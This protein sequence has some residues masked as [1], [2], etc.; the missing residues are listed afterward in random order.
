MTGGLL[1]QWP[2]ATRFGRI[3]PKTKF[4]EHATIAPSVRA[5]FVANI[6]RI[7]WAYKLADTTINLRANAEVPEIQVFVIDA[8][9]DD[10]TDDVLVAMDTAIPFPIIFEITRNSPGHA[11]TR[12]VAAHKQLGGSR[13]RI[14]AYFSTGWLPSDAPRLPLPPALDL[15]GL[16]SSLLAPLLPISACPG[17]GLPQTTERLDRVR[18]LEREIA[19]LERRLRTEPQLNRKFELRR[20]LRERAA[21]LIDLTDPGHTR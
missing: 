4:Y 15:P 19:A 2:P 11:E 8:K 14:S 16:Y 6:H 7:T 13:P 20:E 5:K 10:V 18:K 17:E 12:M 21:T 9:G 1:Y 3:V